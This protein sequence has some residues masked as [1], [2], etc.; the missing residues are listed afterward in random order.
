MWIG[1]FPNCRTTLIFLSLV[2]CIPS[3]NL[4]LRDCYQYLGGSLFWRIGIRFLD[5]QSMYRNLFPVASAWSNNYNIQLILITGLII[6]GLVIDL[7]G[8]L[9]QCAFI[10]ASYLILVLLGGPDHDRR[11]FRYWKHPG[12]MNTCTPAFKAFV[13]SSLDQYHP[14]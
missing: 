2:P 7:G 14:W 1:L 12:A 5:H 9:E 10:S 3:G 6:A 11:G 13:P 4:C 8:L